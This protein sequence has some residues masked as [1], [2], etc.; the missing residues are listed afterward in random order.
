MAINEYSVLSNMYYNNSVRK[1]NMATIRI[2]DYIIDIVRE[3][4]SCTFMDIQYYYHCILIFKD[5][6]GRELRRLDFN[7]MQA[8]QLLD[9]INTFIYDDYAE[10]YALSNLNGPTIYESYSI[11]L[12]AIEQE[13]G[14]HYIQFQVLCTN[15]IYRSITPII[16]ITMSIDDLDRFIDVMFFIYLIDLASERSGIYKT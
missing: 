8:S 5:I 16:T 10:I 2:Q 7:E 14:E 4:V 11:V 6:T 3:D 9:N 1:D 13:S 15:T 12:K